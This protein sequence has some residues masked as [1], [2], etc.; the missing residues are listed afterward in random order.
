MHS[1]LFQN[2]VESKIRPGRA[3]Y[4]HFL[5]NSGIGN[6]FCTLSELENEQNPDPRL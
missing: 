1:Q 2:K 3:V 6:D 4:N 5:T